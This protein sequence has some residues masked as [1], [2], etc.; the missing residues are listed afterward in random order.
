MNSLRS[1]A[2]A[3][4]LRSG[5]PSRAAGYGTSCAQETRHWDEADGRT[6]S[7]RSKEEAYDY[8]YFP[9]PDLVTLDPGPEWIDAV[10]SAM[11]RCRRRSGRGWPRRPVSRCLQRQC[12]PS[13]SLGLDGLISAAVAANVDAALALRRL[14]NEVAGELA[15]NGQH[16]VDPDAFVRLLAL[17]EQG[18]LTS[19]Q[20]RT[21]LRCSLPTGVTRSPLPTKLG[22]QGTG[23][24]CPRGSNGRSYRRQPSRVGA[25]CR[26]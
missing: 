12:R 24:R 10:K 14:A 26:R 17:E 18:E 25:L 5:P 21:V 23:T 9:E 7:M 16:D 2:H 1:L 4:R 20:A 6:H 13:S 11:P 3:C 19:A 8:R 22:L 15:D